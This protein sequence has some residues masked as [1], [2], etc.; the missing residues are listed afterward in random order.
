MTLTNHE[1]QEKRKK[2]Q[3][4]RPLVHVGKNGIT[5]DVVSELGRH[6]KQQKLV[7]V[8]LLPAATEGGAVEDSQAEALAAATH[9]ELVEQRGH[10]AVFWRA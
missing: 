9:S 8:R 4:L 6:L 1:R 3:S 7:K 10:T 2:A 5:D